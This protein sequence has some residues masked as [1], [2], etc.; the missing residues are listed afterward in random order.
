MPQIHRQ[1]LIV[2]PPEQTKRALQR[3]IA[4]R[5]REDRVRI[6]LRP[7]VHVPE[8]GSDIVMQRDIVVEVAA[9]DGFPCRVSWAPAD[10]GAFPR[11]EGTLWVEPAEDG[12][13]SRIVLQGTAPNTQAM[14]AHR[15]SQAVGRDLLAYLAKFIEASGSALAS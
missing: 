13:A 12:A 9:G 1:A 2:C 3:F 8:L 6:A 14:I 5:A 10:D 7:A 11:F 4:E 15:V